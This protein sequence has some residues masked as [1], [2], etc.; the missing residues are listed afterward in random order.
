MVPARMFT[1][2]AFPLTPNRKVDRKALPA[3]VKARAE[4]KP[5]PKAVQPAAANAPTAPAEG[6]RL[7]RRALLETVG[8]VWSEIL[9]VGPIQ[10][11]DNFF[12]LGGHSLLA[13]E[14]HRALRAKLGLKALSIAD[15]FRAPTLSGLVQR[16]ETLSGGGDG[17][18]PSQPSPE[19]ESASAASMADARRALRQRRGS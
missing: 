3:A 2:D 9:G 13:V 11:G 5:V 10:P 6:V 4:A 16:I 18:K 7:D 1:L 14:A 17:P 15:I 19:A 12:D 8:G